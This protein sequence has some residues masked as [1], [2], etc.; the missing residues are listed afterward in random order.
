MNV[1]RGSS[2]YVIFPSFPGFLSDSNAACVVSNARTNPVAPAHAFHISSEFGC[3]QRQKTANSSGA[4][5]PD[6]RSAGCPVAILERLKSF[7]KP[8]P[9]TKLGTTSDGNKPKGVHSFCSVHL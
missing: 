2:L 5:K 8:L 6:C 4:V 9:L 3:S 1:P 7:T